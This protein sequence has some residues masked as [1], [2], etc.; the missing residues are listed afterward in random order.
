MLP[1][2]TLRSS[3]LVPYGR[4]FTTSAHLSKDVPRAPSIRDLT[5][6]D[7]DSFNARQ[8]EFRDNIDAARRQREELDDKNATPSSPEVAQ[9]AT[10]PAAPGVGDGP[11]RPSTFA[12]TA[13]PP[14]GATGTTT[15][16]W[17]PSNLPH[18]LDAASSNLDPSALDSLSSHRVIESHK[19]EPPA[20]PQ[21]RGPLSSLIYGTKEG[22]QLDRDIQRSFSQVLARGKYVHSIVFHEVKPDKVDEYTQLVGE[23]YPKMASLEGNH[24]HLV[25]SWRTQVG[26]NDT[27][28]KEFCSSAAVLCSSYWEERLLT[29]SSPSI[30][31]TFGSTM[32]IPGTTSLCTQLGTT[33][34]SPPSIAS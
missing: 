24:V 27:F 28:G 19:R 7:V 34:N 11:A 2:R 17:P 30:Q 14:T 6:S 3:R 10:S 29:C 23:W 5:Q 12:S 8:K 4:L 31:C 13:V 15:T 22:Q 9:A 32:G 20:K 18:G 1:I 26:D 33:P 25:G 16:A 21:K